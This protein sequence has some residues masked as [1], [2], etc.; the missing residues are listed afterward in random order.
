MN[1]SDQIVK[2]NEVKEEVNTLVI[3][4]EDSD[5]R[6]IKRRVIVVPEKP[7][8]RLEV[9]P[10]SIRTRSIALSIFAPSDLFTLAVP[11]RNNALNQDESIVP[12][13]FR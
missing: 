7:G 6:L 13:F 1:H 10:N 8:S 5:Q 12:E 9:S 3:G 4:D 11:W 2:L